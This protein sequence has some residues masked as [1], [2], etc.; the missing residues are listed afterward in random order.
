MRTNEPD[1]ASQ[2]V[3][4]RLAAR[5]ANICAAAVQDFDQAP[6]FQE[7]ERLAHDVAAH[8]KFLGKLLLRG[9][10]CT[11]AECTVDDRFLDLA[12]DDFRQALTF[13]SLEAGHNLVSRS[14]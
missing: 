3:T 14:A 2:G 4:R 12:G 7:L 9:Q 13:D 11:H 6:L 10:L 1:I 8:A 5:L